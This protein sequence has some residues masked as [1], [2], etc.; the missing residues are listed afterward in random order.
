MNPG[1]DVPRHEPEQ[2]ITVRLWDLPL[3]LCH[4][5]T[6]P[7]V[8][9]LWLTGKSGPLG[10]HKLFGYV[11][12]GI[13]LFRIY[14][15]FFGT[16]SARFAQFLRGPAVVWRYARNLAL[17]REHYAT[18]GHNPLGGWNVVGMMS[19]LLLECVLGL[20]A[21]DVD[22]LESGPL[23]AHISFN[24]GRQMARLH[25]DMF[26]LLMSLV[27]LHIAAIGVH[28]IGRREN[29]IG[30]MLTGDK[31][32]TRTHEVRPFR[33]I[34]SWRAWIGLGAIGL[35]VVLLVVAL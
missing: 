25:Y 23:A 5:L 27:A 33:S 29:L 26:Y 1:H 31:R 17:R 21:V 10:L 18:L 2:A 4:W 24:G 28:Y 20:F 9:L 15:G 16:E 34:P 22:G 30:P 14:W 7:L 3:R 32:I 8:G 6:V 13:V 19:L 12:L 35:L 11:I